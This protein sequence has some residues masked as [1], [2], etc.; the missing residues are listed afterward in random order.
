M[1]TNMKHKL[2]L[3]TIAVLSAALCI[4]SYAM[5]TISASNMIT[6]SAAQSSSNF[7]SDY[8]SKI[9]TTVPNNAVRGVAHKVEPI[10]YMSA[11]AGH[12]KPATVLLPEN[13]TTDKKYPVLYLNHGIFGGEYDMLGFS[14]ADMAYNLAASG[15]AKEMIIVCTQMFTAPEGNK[16]LNQTINSETEQKYD[17]FIYDLTE[18]LMPYIESH[19][20]VATGKENTGIAGFSMGARE[21]LYIG[22]SHPEL[23]GYIGAACPAPGAVPGRDN[24]GN[25]IGSMT[26]D[27]FRIDADKMPYM[28]MIA[29]GTNDGVVG[30]FPKQYSNLLT[31]NETDHIFIEI[32]GGD[33]GGSVVTPMMYNFLKCAFQATPSSTTSDNIKG[34]VNHDGDFNISDVVLL[35][36]WLL[37]VPN[38]ELA[39]WKAA[40]MSD[41]NT[42]DV[43]DLCLMKNKLTG[44]TS[45]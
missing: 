4:C 30:D 31:K 11:K 22:V 25:H 35:Q 24:F 45:V 29:G 14:I 7:M 6:V 17:D 3:K 26:E 9:V 34:D 42:L 33:H 32:P 10:T 5:P 20:S 41:D 2:P 21:S 19:Y 43:S 1:N 40:D 15:E 12:E 18:S 13:Y 38:T 39:D 37:S 36:K 27:E 8:K 28:L 23:F 44:K 16:P